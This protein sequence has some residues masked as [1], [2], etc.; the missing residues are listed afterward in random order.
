M[1]KYQGTLPL[2]GGLS[3]RAQR[4]SDEDF[5]LGLFIDARPWLAKAHHDRD[6][7][8]MMYEQQYG[9]MRHGQEERYPEHLDFVVEKAGQAVGRLII[10]LG[11]CDWRIAEVEIHRLARSK[12]I[13]SDLI[14]SIQGT[15][16]QTGVPMTL[17]VLAAQT[18]VH[19]FY[20]RLGFQMLGNV[21]PM[22][23]LIWLPPGHPGLQALPPQLLPQTQQGGVA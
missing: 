15:A 12:G 3:I 23:E 9:A 4:P 16:A 5:L 6:F 8:R 14:R 17:S 2:L 18:R 7:I 10:D 1:T 13:G 11:R 20:F 21:P 22:L 19:W